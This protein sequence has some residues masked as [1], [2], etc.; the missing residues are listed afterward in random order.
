MPQKPSV[1]STP[2]RRVAGLCV[3]FLAIS[4][5][6]SLAVLRTRNIYDDEIGTY[7]V[8]PQTTLEIVKKI[9]HT[10]VHPPG[11][12]VLDHLSYVLLPSPRWV[13]LFPLCCLYAGLAVFVFYVTPLFKTGS[14]RFCFLLIATLHPQLVMWGNSI[15]WYPWWT[16]IALLASSIVAGLGGTTKTGS[17]SGRRALGLGCLVGCLFYINYVTIL[18]A[19]A[20]A[21]GAV[22]RYG[23]RAWK[24]LCLAA[25]VAALMIAPQLHAFLTYHMHGSGGQRYNPLLSTARL[26]Q[27]IFSSEAYLPWHPLAL[28]AVAVM[29]LLSCLGLWRAWRY[30]RRQNWSVHGPDAP[31]FSVLVIGLTFFLAVSLSGLGGKPRNG[32]ALIPLLAPAAGLVVSGMRSRLA[33]AATLLFLA[34][35]SCWGSV[36]LVRRYGL[37]KS[38]MNN[39]PEEVLNFIKESRGNACS[40]VVTYDPVLT[41]YLFESH[42]RSQ[43]VLTLSQNRMYTRATPFKPDQ[44]PATKLYVVQSYLGGL[45]YYTDTLTTELR[46]GVQHIRGP[47]KVNRFSYDPDAAVKRRLKF[48]SGSA[49]LPDYRYVV[50]SGEISPSDLDALEAD[51]P[52][53]TRADG[54]SQPRLS[55]ERK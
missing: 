31:I 36:H 5:A 48:I 42:V 24:A 13:T 49:T 34:V 51:M 45:E 50:T 40:V 18:F 55:G 17:M 37:T 16:G 43:L 14:A 26:V 21:A 46:H 28:L 52:Y 15:R 8:L 41:F 9:N 25:F 20:L 53:L 6:L 38:G 11:M 4:F 39:R 12:Y 33:Q 7:D 19:V 10:D 44:C 54:Y 47:A 22:A 3:L 2:K 35:W 23:V 29:L 32:L 1:F 30:M 27:S